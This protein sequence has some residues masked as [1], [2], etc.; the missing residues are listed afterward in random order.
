MRLSSALQVSD[1]LTCFDHSLF[2]VGAISLVFLLLL[3]LAACFV[4]LLV[5][6]AVFGHEN[7][8]ITPAQFKIKRNLELTPSQRDSVN[9][10]NAAAEELTCLDT[11]LCKQASGE[12]KNLWK[13]EVRLCI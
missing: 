6:A 3:V 9:N 13:A 11:V 10:E 5:T 2:L 7:L 1:G 4:V 12:S 8:T